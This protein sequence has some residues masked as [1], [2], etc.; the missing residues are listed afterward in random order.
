M[1]FTLN[2]RL[3]ADRNKWTLSNWISIPAPWPVDRV[4]PPEQQQWLI[5]LTGIVQ[6]EFRSV[7]GDAFQSTA[8]NLV[9]DL[10]GPLAAS[11][12]QVPA[13]SSLIFQVDQWAPYATINSIFDGS[14]PANAG[15]DVYSCWPLFGTRH[16]Q[17][18][19]LIS[20]VFEG[21]GVEVAARGIDAFI[22]R[23]G[24]NVTLLGH[25][26]VNTPPFP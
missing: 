22:R 4:P 24:Y 2:Q 14:Q 17:Y 6:I 12:L 16:D 9:P 25:I 8:F 1:T 10:G 11:G 26:L 3:A 19:G 23:V 15:W 7:E 13:G 18:L 20:Q 5:V 21:L